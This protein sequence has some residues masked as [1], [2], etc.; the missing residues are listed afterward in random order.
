MSF[1][2]TPAEASRLALRAI[3]ER[4]SGAVGVHLPLG[5]G[6]ES[7]IPPIRPG[8]LVVIMAK[9]SNYK[10]GFMQWWSRKIAQSFPEDDASSAVFYVTWEQAVEEIIIFDLAYQAGI[11]VSN[12]LNGT[13]T[14]SERKA[15]AKALS[16][17][18]AVPIYIIGHSLGGGADRPNMT[19][20]DVTR[21]IDATS[22]EHNIRP[23][24]VFLDYL[25]QIEPERGKDRRMEVFH[26]V[27]RAKDMALSLSCPVIMGS[28]VGRT[29]YERAWGMPRV[30]EGLESSNIEHTADRVFGLVYPITSLPVNTKVAI[31]ASKEITV[32]RGALYMQVLKQRMGR[33]GALYELEVDPSRNEISLVGA[34]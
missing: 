9:T 2:H 33:C 31:T 27:A 18:S 17:R 25:Q 16:H 12:L 23:V 19:L 34:V 30:H 28:Q 10:T 14:E 8:E 26:N 32:R 15:L 29:V 1:V 5:D 21:L 11:P 13:I 7:Y 20:N 3:E 24:A 22:K 4:M 6:I